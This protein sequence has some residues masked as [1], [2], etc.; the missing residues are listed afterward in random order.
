MNHKTFING[1]GVGGGK[2]LKFHEKSQKVQKAFK[3]K[4]QRINPKKLA[5]NELFQHVCSPKQGK[6]PGALP[7]DPTRET[8][9]AIL[10]S[11]LHFRQ[12]NTRCSTRNS[13]LHT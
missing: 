4:K 9:S 12:A 1:D 3:F 6:L 8:H 13:I 7:Q 10:D 2:S 5:I 11:H